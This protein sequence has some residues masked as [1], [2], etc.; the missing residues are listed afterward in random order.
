MLDQICLRISP[1]PLPP[2]DTFLNQIAIV[3]GGTGGLGLAAAAH[4]VNLGAKQVII[5]S[6]SAPRAKHALEELERLTSGKSAEPGRVRVMELD[7]ASFKSVVAFVEEAGK[8]NVGRGGVDCVVLNAGVVSV[9]YDATDDG[10]EQALQVNAIS[11]ALLARLL[12]ESMLREHPHRKTPAHMALTGSTRHTDGDVDVL[13]RWAKTDGIV[14]HLNKPENYPGS[15][16]TYQ[17]T[18]LLAHYAMENV[19]E[20]A[21]DRDSGR[22]RVIVNTCCPGVVKTDL[23]RPFVSQNAAYAVGVAVFQGVLGKTAEAGARTLLRAVM[24][25]EEQHGE[26]IRFYGS[27]EKYAVQAEKLFR[28]ETGKRVR[29]SLW[30]EFGAIVRDKVPEVADRFL[31]E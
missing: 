15:S 13:G 22:P 30:R 17:N 18:K 6:R 2:A 4:F 3:T 23:A 28:S 25:D 16:L 20:L 26:F 31:Q 12:L 29:A 24:T 27:K 1:V 10:F 7:M 19:A 14:G 11:T 9:E 21:R 5:T 8:I